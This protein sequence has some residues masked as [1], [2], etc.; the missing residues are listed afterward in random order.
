MKDAVRKALK[1]P[2]LK[3]LKVFTDW[4]MFTIFGAT[5][6]RGWLGGYRFTGDIRCFDGYADNQKESIIFTHDG[7]VRV[8]NKS[9]SN[10]L[11]G[12][13]LDGI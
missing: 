9:R 10:V 3:D 6:V 5:V 2:R 13:C 1:Q 8:N 11:L 12:V 7:P 4:S